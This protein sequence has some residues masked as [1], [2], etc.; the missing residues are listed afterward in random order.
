M[1]KGCP[2]NV[3]SG[4]RSFLICQFHF[5][6]LQNKA[7]ASEDPKKMARG[8]GTQLGCACV[9]ST[10]RQG[11]SLE[12]AGGQGREQMRGEPCSTQTRNPG[13]DLVLHWL[14]DL[15]QVTYPF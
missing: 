1:C 6:S 10:R 15:G 4:F 11:L 14:C 8:E 7:Q 13:V 2:G 3:I 12:S 9:G 5:S